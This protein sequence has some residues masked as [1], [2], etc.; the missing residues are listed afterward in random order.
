MTSITISR[1]QENTAKVTNT[2]PPLFIAFPSSL[3][4]S[5]YFVQ[6]PFKQTLLCPQVTLKLALTP[7]TV[8]VVVPEDSLL[9]LTHIA[10]NVNKINMLMKTRRVNVSGFIFPGNSLGQKGEMRPPVD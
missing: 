5:V 3:P 7:P 9:P 4:P 8:I 6:S 10:Q 1:N 2:L